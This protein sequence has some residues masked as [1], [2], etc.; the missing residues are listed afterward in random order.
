MN[1]KILVLS[2]KLVGE[3][4]DNENM[5]WI[6]VAF[7]KNGYEVVHNVWP[8]IDLVGSV[9]NVSAWADCKNS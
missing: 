4:N 5:L 8:Y 6:S 1:K 7:D 3:K 2:L 9:S